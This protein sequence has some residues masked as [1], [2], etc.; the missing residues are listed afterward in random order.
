M[1]YN[2]CPDPSNSTRHPGMEAGIIQ[3][4]WSTHEV[5]EISPKYASS[6]IAA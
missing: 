1:H 3:H 5:I 6:A 2:F 4:V